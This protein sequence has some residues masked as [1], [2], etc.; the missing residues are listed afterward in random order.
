MKTIKNLLGGS[1]LALAVLTQPTQAADTIKPIH[2][3]AITWETGSLITEGLRL[4]V[5]KG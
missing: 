5:E 4:I 2:F 3:G 1:L